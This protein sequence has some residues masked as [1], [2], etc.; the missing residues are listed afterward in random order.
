LSCITLSKVMTALDDGEIAPVT[1][2]LIYAIAHFIGDQGKMHGTII[3]GVL[4][5]RLN[6]F[7][8]GN[9]SILSG[10]ELMKS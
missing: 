2:L 8:D 1:V 6:K 9:A 10:I 5:R 7:A 3:I 4:D